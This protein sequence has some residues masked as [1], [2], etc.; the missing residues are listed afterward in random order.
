MQEL[1][2]PAFVFGKN[3]LAKIGACLFVAIRLLLV[4]DEIAKTHRELKNCS[5]NQQKPL[6]RA[7]RLIPTKIAR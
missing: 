1:R 2:A 4:K 6:Q 3:S 5:A 7:A